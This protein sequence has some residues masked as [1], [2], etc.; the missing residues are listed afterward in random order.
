MNSDVRTGQ[1]REWKQGAESHVG[2]RFLV[3]GFKEWVDADPTVVLM[4]GGT[5][6]NDFYV[7][8]VSECSKVVEEAP[9]TTADYIIPAEVKR[10]VVRIR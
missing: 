9:V 5:V 4:E 1:L 10:Q 3:I 2:E 7:A 6:Y 8:Y